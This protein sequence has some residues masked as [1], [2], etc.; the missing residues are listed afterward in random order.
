MLLNNIIEETSR[1]RERF[2]N[3]IIWCF[4]N[5]YIILHQLKKKFIFVG[6]FKGLRSVKFAFLIKKNAF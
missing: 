1:E 4:R 3:I 6:F 2:R 5:I